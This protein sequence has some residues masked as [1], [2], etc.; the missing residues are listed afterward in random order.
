MTQR[1]CELRNQVIP[2]RYHLWQRRPGGNMLALVA[3]TAILLVCLLMFGLQFLSMSRGHMEQ[4]TAA[5]AAALAAAQE[6][7]KIVINTPQ[8][9]FVGL[10]DQ[11]PTGTGTLAADNWSC[12]VRSINE[13]IGAARLEYI[14]ATE[15]GDDFMKQLAIKDRDDAIAAKDLLVAEI[16]KALVKGGKAKDVNGNDLTPYEDAEAIYKKNNAKNSTYVD[17]TMNLSLGS[18][19]GGIGTQVAIPNPDSKAQLNPGQKLGGCYLSDTNMPYGTE[20]FVFAS[21]GKQVALADQSKFRDNIA[22]LSY[23]IPAVVRVDADQDFVE[24]GKPMKMHFAACA[25]AGG[26]VQRPAAGAL[27]IGF[28]DGPVPEITC[29]RDLFTFDQMGS[30]KCDVLTALGGDF[31]VDS[32]AANIDPALPWPAPPWPSS[33][34]SAADLA[35]LGLYDWVRAGGSRVNIDSVVRMQ[36]GA[37][38]P[39]SKAMTTWNSKDPMTKIAL[40]LGQI[41]QGVAHI[42]T[43]APDGS[44]LYRSKDIKTEP[45]TI[46]ANNQ[47]YAEL[48][49]DQEIKSGVL[50]WKIVGISVNLPEKGKPGSFK[51]GAVDI[52]GTNVY[53]FYM[54]DMVRQRGTTLGGKHTGEPLD[55]PIVGFNRAGQRKYRL[56]K[57]DNKNIICLIPDDDFEI[58]GGGPKPKGGFGAPSLISR[59][60]DF[61]TTGL[62]AP[63][64]NQYAKNAGSGGA[65]PTY[66]KNGVCVEMRFRRQVKVGLLAVLLGGFDVGYIGE[67]L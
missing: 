5:E 46:A 42:Y 51:A 6:I 10:V 54:R 20:G 49:E 18:I 23:Q 8:C 22:G 59:Q 31:P 41:P 35:R 57:T 64:Y 48:S 27:T 47:V 26:A 17:G 55:D 1:P 38:D 2:G 52:E 58:G 45:Y 39:P 29:P 65:R 32:P 33:P 11:P 15:L 19:E 30:A 21:T 56:E 7:G 61:A 28:P 36:T 13:L 25:T 3:I 63:Q 66:T 34:P 53:D 37:F 14:I 50:P 67:M 9:G 16:N 40:T 62:P 60:D 24:Q 12:E 43:F 44:I 4:K